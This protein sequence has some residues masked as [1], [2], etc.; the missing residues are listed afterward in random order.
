MN[1]KEKYIASLAPRVR[2]THPARSA[3]A[4]N[5]SGAGIVHRQMMDLQRQPNLN[6][7]DTSR[8]K[9][10]RRDW[11]RNR[12]YTDAGMA[13]AGASSPLDA[14]KYFVDTTRDF[15]DTNRDAY[16]SMY[17]LTNMA[18]EYPQKG[19]ILGMIA[20]E[21]FGKISD[22]GKSIINKEGI[23]G[24][25]DSDEAEMEDYAAKTFGAA[26]PYNIHEDEFTDTEN[27]YDDRK[28]V[29]IPPLDNDFGAFT[30]LHPF[31]D[32]RRE[33]AIMARYPGR[34]D[35]PI[36]KRPNMYDVA[37]PW[38]GTAPLEDVTISEIDEDK[39][40]KNL[41]SDELWDSIRDF[42]PS[43]IGIPGIHVGEDIIVP[44]WLLDP[45]LPMPPELLEESV[46]EV[47]TPFDDS[48]RETGI[49]N[50]MR[51]PYSR[52]NRS[53][54]FPPRGPHDPFDPN[55]RIF[56]DDAEYRAWLRR[57]RLGY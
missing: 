41:I 46:E 25:A 31:D 49:M 21:I 56:E 23:A 52:D 26:Y 55:Q 3:Q 17:P 2:R 13:I 33:A 38:F 37:G 14:Q 50:A 19:G 43:T 20:K 57:K 18:M 9:D 47:I 54:R 45:S 8:L 10:L 27:W 42:D 39:K 32:S 4:L 16:A 6:K 29:V 30:S 28:D 51:S 12:K 34:K 5:T 36:P 44:P 7:A 40:G 53:L 15:R 24:A 48:A 11:N 35:V 22:F 1:D